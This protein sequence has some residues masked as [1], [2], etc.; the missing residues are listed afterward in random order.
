MIESQV[1]VLY[2]TEDEWQPY[3]TCKWEEDKNESDDIPEQIFKAQSEHRRE[4]G[5]VQVRYF[6][7]QVKEQL[8]AYL[9]T[10][11]CVTVSRLPPHFISLHNPI[12]L[13]I[14]SIER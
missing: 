3:I 4:Y 13:Q 7:K 12:G 10:K 6:Q 2:Y 1:W 9:L 8:P 5:T 14:W 11:N